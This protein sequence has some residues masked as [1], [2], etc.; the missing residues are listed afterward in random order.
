MGSNRIVLGPRLENTARPTF[1]S[2]VGECGVLVELDSS[3]LLKLIPAVSSADISHLL[4]QQRPRITAAA[5]RLFDQGFYNQ[6]DEI[7]ITL[8]ALDL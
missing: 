8:T 6:V 4:D 3:A 2:R 5:Q 1:L 7:V